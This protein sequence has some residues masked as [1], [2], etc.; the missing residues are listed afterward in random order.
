MTNA[1]LHAACQALHSWHG[2]ACARTALAHCYI[3]FKDCL[4]YVLLTFLKG[5]KS[6][7]NNRNPTGQSDS[8]FTYARW[9]VSSLPA[10]HGIRCDR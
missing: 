4:V 10:A 9:P 8:Y 2:M 1:H 6:V 7:N 5:Q 3:T